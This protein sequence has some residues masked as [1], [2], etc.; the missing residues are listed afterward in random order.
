M[1]FKFSIP[2]A[3]DTCSEYT[4]LIVFPLQQW[5][6][7][8]PHCYFIYLNIF[9]VYTGSFKVPFYESVKNVCIFEISFLLYTGVAP[10][11]D[12]LMHWTVAKR[13]NSSVHEFVLYYTTGCIGLAQPS[14]T[15]ETKGL[16]C[17]PTHPFTRSLNQSPSD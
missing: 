4:I 17:P 1:R 2:K 6:T 12:R 16:T 13:R 14:Q 7:N 11:C 15:D 8:T 9:W 3:T 5:F 10:C